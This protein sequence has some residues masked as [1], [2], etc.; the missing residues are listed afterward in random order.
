M[1]KWKRPGIVPQKEDQ[2]VAHVFSVMRLAL[3][4][5]TGVPEGYELPCGPK[6]HWEMEE[7]AWAFFPNHHLVIA[8]SNGAAMFSHAMGDDYL[9]A[10]SYRKE[11]DKAAH[12]VIGA[13]SLTDDMVANWVLAVSIERQWK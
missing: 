3:G 8:R 11:S 2:C 5:K 10:W 9:V 1:G 6:N 12:A 13:P 4:Y 7:M